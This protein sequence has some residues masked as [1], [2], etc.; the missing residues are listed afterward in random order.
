MLKLALRG[1]ARIVPVALAVTFGVFV[2]V[3]LAPGDPARILAGENA[4]PENIAYIRRTLHLDDGL[5][6]RYW[7]W[8]KD[9]LHGDLGTSFLTR[10]SVSHALASRLPVTLSLILVSTVVSLV[11]A[12]VAALIAVRRPGGFVD[13][14]VR[15]IASVSLAIPPFWIGMVL[16]VI[17]AVKNQ[18]F[19]AIGYVSFESSPTGWL[20]HLVLPS[21]AL[22]TASFASY[23]LQLRNSMLGV[24]GQEYVLAATARGIPRSTIMLKHALKNAAI[25]LVTVFGST[26]AQLLGGAVTVETV[27]GIPGVGQYA[28]TSV[29][30]RDFPALLGI[31]LV[32]TL[33]ILVLNVLVD[34]SYGYFNP[35]VRAQ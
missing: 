34:L 17:F 30:G 21:I 2:A 13:G 32:T 24:L 10:E 31:L 6:P 9:A 27:F 20:E 22:A 23:T 5:L 18:I 3:S 8:L 29:L 14:M 11:A 25:P 12:I 35:K 7:Y 4:T 19:P 16:V 28:V 15:V 1:V 26:V 33:L